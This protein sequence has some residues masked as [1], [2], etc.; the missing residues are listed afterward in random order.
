MPTINCPVKYIREASRAFGDWLKEHLKAPSIHHHTS[1]TGYPVSPDCFNIVYR[2]T[3][4][5]T[6]HIKEAMYIR[7][8]DP[9]LN[10]NLGKY[11]LPHVWDQILQDTPGLKLK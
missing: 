11:Q 6:R 1:S 10:R 4:G 5:T 8:N 9:S 2:E 7:A 3:K